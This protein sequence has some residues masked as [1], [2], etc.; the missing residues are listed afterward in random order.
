M[1]GGRDFYEKICQKRFGSQ[2]SGQDKAIFYFK[3]L[4]I[5]QHTLRPVSIS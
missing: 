5:L 2:A 4:P 1:T 3:E